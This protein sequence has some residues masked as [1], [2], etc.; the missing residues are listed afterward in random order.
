[1][2]HFLRNARIRTRVALAFLPAM[3]GL[4][5]ACGILL[6]NAWTE[7]RDMAALQ[8]LTGI[9]PSISNLV[10]ELQKERGNSAGFL[11][12]KGEG[13]FVQRLDDQRKATDAALVKYKESMAGFPASQ[14][15]ASMTERVA[16]AQAGVGNLDA[17]RKAVSALSTDVGAAAKYYTD[18]IARLL[19]VVTEGASLGS[20][21]AVSQSVIAYVA[22]LQAKERV[23]IERAMGSNGFSAG[24]FAPAVYQN[25]VKLAGQ[26][27]AYLAVF[28]E[29]ATP[30][31]REFFAATVKGEAVDA[32][33]RM[34]QIAYDSPF[35]GH[36]GEVK[37]TEWFDAITQKINLMKTVEDRLAQD[38]VGLSGIV[39]DSAKGRLVTL[40]GVVVALVLFT[41]FFALFVIRGIV[42][43]LH[44]MAQ[45]VGKLAAGE[46]NVE[47]PCMEIGRAHV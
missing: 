24:V 20:N 41:T 6:F 26:Q 45:G 33:E 22:F 18:T 34:R 40:S 10:H 21:K 3:A 35:T 39:H 43:P 15:G 7:A 5:V 30:E 25:Y 27:L 12:A 42:D 9:A 13:V 37:G 19:E 31:Q 46:S 44:A 36:T 11:G 4:L 8:R 14:Y 29:N 28:R 2:L 47:I 16:A 17:T 1:M 32:V 38:V 23:G